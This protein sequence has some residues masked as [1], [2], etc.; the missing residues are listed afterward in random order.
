MVDSPPPPAV[1]VAVV[2]MAIAAHV[3]GRVAKSASWPPLWVL[4]NPLSAVAGAFAA[5][6]IS[7]GGGEAMLATFAFLM[8][9]FIA[10]LLGFMGGQIVMRTR[11]ID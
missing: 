8:G 6:Y 1:V 5:G 11:D 3:Y 10:L 4:F 7:Q 2:G 9:G